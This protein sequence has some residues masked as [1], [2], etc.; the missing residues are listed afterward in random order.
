MKHAGTDRNGLRRKSAEPEDSVAAGQ[1]ASPRSALEELHVSVG[2]RVPP[3]LEPGHAEPL[4]G[5]RYERS[6]VLS[7]IPLR[8]GQSGMARA[9]E[10][11][12]QL[13][14]CGFARFREC[15]MTGFE[16]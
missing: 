2:E 16:A 12:R 8:R 6:P 13:F 5:L 1:F 14:M 9:V 3:N 7:W 4:F 10:E 15:N 11:G